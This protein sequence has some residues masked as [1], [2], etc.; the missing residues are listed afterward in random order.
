LQGGH[1]GGVSFGGAYDRGGW[2]D[3]YYNEHKSLTSVTIN[4]N[5]FFGNN[6][7]G[8]FTEK[9]GLNQGGEKS[10]IWL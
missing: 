8:T 10:G 7:D 2:L 5:R 9:S 4:R 1:E 6:A 3:L